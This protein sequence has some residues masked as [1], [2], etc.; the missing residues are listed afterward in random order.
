MEVGL[1]DPLL[2]G[3]LVL[4]DTPGIGS[5]DPGTTE[6]AY[7]FLPRVDAAILVLS[8]DPPLGEAE[9]A[10]VRTLLD[11]TRHILFVLNKVD[12]YP[13]SSWREAM[14]FN[15]RGL[16]RIQGVEPETVELLPVSAKLGLDG[17]SGGIPALKKR[18]LELVERA[19][20]STLS[21]WVQEE[22]GVVLPSPPPPA[23]LVDSHHF[24]YH[25]QGMRPELT[26]DLLGLLLPRRLFRWR[27]RRRAHRLVAEDLDRNVGRIRG[28]ILYR[29]Q[30][31]V[32]AFLAELERRLGFRPAALRPDPGR[33][34][35][36]LASHWWETVLNCRSQVLRGY[37]ELD[38]ETG[39]RMDPLL[40]EVAAALLSLS[41][42]GGDR[43]PE[44]EG[45]T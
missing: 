19:T 6:R 32:R 40:D 25:V 10:Y 28:D 45:P 24:Y 29:A 12:L 43:G 15:R 23:E 5:L 38:P 31:T 39:P 41:A 3:G 35:Q 27:F 4:V 9:G 16:G 7:A 14:E 20:A 11:H 2:E 17:G 8:P 26:V 34:L 44:A 36:A 30:E 21:A 37:G 42:L 33:R 22:L 18:L 1:A 13:E